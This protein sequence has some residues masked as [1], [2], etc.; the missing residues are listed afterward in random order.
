[1]QGRACR[2]PRWMQPLVCLVKGCLKGKALETHDGDAMD[3]QRTVLGSNPYPDRP[4]L[5]EGS[6]FVGRRLYLSRI[7]SRI[8]A[9]R[10]Q[11]ISLVGEPRI[12]K[13]S[14]LHR[15]FAPEI[16][17]RYLTCPEEYVFVLVPVQPGEAFDFAAFSRQ[18]CR[19]V[20]QAVARHLTVEKQQ[21]S[22]DFFK[23]IVEQ[24]HHH[25][26]K[27]VIFF[28][29]FHLVTQNPSF[30]LEFFSFLRSLAN[31]YPL[32][33]VTTSFLDLQKLCVSKEIEESPFFNIF[34]NMTLKP[35]EEAEAGQYIG[36]S[37]EAGCSLEPEA[38]RLWQLA[39]GFPYPLQQSCHLAF[40]KKRQLGS[41]NEAH[42]QALEDTLHHSLADYLQAMEDYFSEEQKQVLHHL[43][44]G[45]SVPAALQYLQAD[46]Q[47]RGYLKQEHGHVALATRLLEDHFRR[48]SGRG[49]NKPPRA[50]GRAWRRWLSRLLP[51][52]T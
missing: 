6:L 1:M 18:L 52:K 34:T 35:L 7:Y 24:L 33:Y 3:S 48:R 21:P 4:V 23:Q 27:M 14:L 37:R 41:L 5:A 20:L 36:L 28:D 51:W 15:L 42:W 10:P 11:S 30:P 31:N 40:Q 17:T 12:G 39:G 49:N 2:L 25:G 43:V 26:K 19:Q 9:Q 8:G 29:D 44:A 38:E 13:S 50:A 45:E 32:A 47:R 46:L 16:R 22:Y